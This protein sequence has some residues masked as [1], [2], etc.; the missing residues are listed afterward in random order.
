MGDDIGEVEALI[1]QLFEPFDF[2]VKLAVLQGP[3]NLQ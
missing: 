3:F 1:E 2:P